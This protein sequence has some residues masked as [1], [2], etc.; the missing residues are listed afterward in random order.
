MVCCARVD[1]H[2]ATVRPAL[3]ARK[4]V[5]CEWPLA[6]TIAAVCGIRWCA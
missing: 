5:F 2:Y 4:M 6:H 1:V 3:A